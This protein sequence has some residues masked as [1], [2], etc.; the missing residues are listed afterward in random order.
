[1]KLSFGR[2]R[3]LRSFALLCVVLLGVAS[4][5]VA[6]DAARQSQPIRSDQLA[7]VEQLKNEAFKSLRAGNFDKSDELLRTAASLSGD[8]SLAQMSQWLGQYATQ[9]QEFQAERHKQFEK[10]VAGVKKLNDAGLLRHAIDKTSEAHALA[11]D[12]EEFVKQPWVS[13]ML[14]KATELAAKYESEG[15]WLQALYVYTD[16]RSVDPANAKW[17]QGQE[18][19]RR[20]CRLL[21]MYT[22]DDYKALVEADVKDRD[23][24]AKLLK[25]PSTQPTTE[26]ATR[27]LFSDN[28]S[29]KTDWRDSLRGVQL[30]MLLDALGNAKEN[31]WKDLEYKKLLHGGL[32]GVRALVTT[33]G[34]EKEFPNLADDTKRDTFAAVI[35]QAQQTVENLGDRQDEQIFTVKR[36]LANL[37]L[38]NRQ[39]VQLPDEVLVNEFADGAFGELD[40]FSNMIWPADLEEFNKSTQGEFGGVGIQ[41]INDDDM[42]LKVASPL[43]DTPAYKLGIKAGDIISKI[44]G[45]NARGIS[46]TMAVKTI[47]GPPGTSVT[48]TIRSP[49]GTEKD[50]TIRREIINVASVKGWK[51]LPGGAWDYFIDPQQKIGYLRLTNFT[52]RSS[53]ELDSA[54]DEVRESGA[55][56]L[57]LDLRY[58]PGG[59]LTAATEISDKFL[60]GGTIVS[61]RAERENPAQA[62][63]S[64]DARLSDDDFDLPMVV[65]VNQYSASAS[66]IVSGALKDQKRAIVVG[67]RTFGKGSVQMLFSLAGRTAYLKLTTSHYYLPSGKCI[68]KEED[69]KSWG[70]DPDVTVEM[71]PEQSRDAIEARQDQEVL[72]SMDDVAVA[73]ATPATEPST[74]PGKVKKPLLDTDA[75]LSAALLVLRLQLAGATL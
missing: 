57:I 50:Y 75:Q 25:E 41:I 35:D 74:K 39:T 60:K 7:T 33:K 1:M 8:R 59:L 53:E 6:Q 61:T 36:T 58:N 38:A 3:I 56:G 17:K 12:K 9:R 23:Q 29:F 69:S 48:L 30:S 37:R 68:H 19:A 66:E 34:L 32:K 55:R 5:V 31:Y 63:Q 46:T 44:N 45:K 72:R 64:A 13:E 14:T 42:N 71:T 27:P 52:K 2:R 73:V 28:D 20:H 54:I 21:A 4:G 11:D 26:P 15:Q 49:D 24:A 16:L 40:D 43:E 18:A 51:R 67:E 47:T 22:P 62:P 65:L 10:S 70:V